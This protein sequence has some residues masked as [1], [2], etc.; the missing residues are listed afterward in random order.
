MVRRL[1]WE[2]A[3]EVEFTYVMGGIREFADAEREALDWLEAAAASGMA[4]DA[5]LWLDGGPETSYPAC[6]AVVAAAEQGDPGPYL[7]RLR[8]GFALRRRRLD[9]PEAFMVEARELGGVDLERFRVELESNA[10]VEAF[11]AHLERA[12]AVSREHWSSGAG[13]VKLPSIEFRGD[14]GT[15][16]V[17][18]AYGPRPY[19]DYVA[20][21]R[22]AGASPSGRGAPSVEEA[23]RHFGSMTTA[24]I[25]AVCGLAGP[26]APAELW[27]LA[28]EWV[29]AVE[30]LG[31]GE[32]WRLA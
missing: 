5:R 22:A 16:E 6:M 4:V 18:G 31:S 24:E 20:A 26:R 23:L 3:A 1:A 14:G 11:G 30:R 25:A 8:E 29:V 21:A 9:H 27:R 32:L 19:D 28:S 12:R 15:G 17:H 13:R 2:F 7:R 10:I